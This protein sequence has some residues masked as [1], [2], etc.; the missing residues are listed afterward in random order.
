MNALQRQF[1]EFAPQKR[2]M[3]YGEAIIE[4]CYELLAVL[5]PIV[6]QRLGEGFFKEVELYI[7]NKQ[8]T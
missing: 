5:K 1:L 4:E 8:K 3:V 7:H 2:V 6:L